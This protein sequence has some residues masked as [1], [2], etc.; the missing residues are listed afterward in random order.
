MSKVF[1]MHSH[2]CAELSTEHIGQEVCLTGWVAKRRDHG[3]LIFV[4]LRDREGI[5]Q[6]TF[7]PDSSGA[8]FAEAERIRPEWSVK[9]EGTVRRRPEGTENTQVKT[10]K[11]EI[12]VHSLQVLNTSK[13]PPFSIEDAI[14]TDE[15]TRMKYRYLDL[16]RP[17]MFKALKLRN[18]MSFA[19][20]SAFAARGFIEVETPI[21]TKSTPEGARDFIVPSRN[22]VGAFYALPQSPQ[23][24]KQLLMVGGIERYY[25]FAR[26]FRDEDLRA[27]RQPE[28]TQVDVEMSYVTQED[29][30][31]TMESIFVECLAQMGVELTVPL[32]R[33]QYRDAMNIYGS[34]RPDTR[35]GMLLHQLCAIFEN[36]EF[37]VFAQAVQTGKVVKCIN[38][39]G[40]A[41]LS[42][43]DIDKLNQFAL[44]HGAQGLAW[45]AF[46]HEGEIKS[47]IK[48]FLSDSEI[49]A[50]KSEME[51]E[52]GDLLL[53]VADELS[54]ANEVLGALRLHLAELLGI[55]RPGHACLWVVNFP[56]FKYDEEEKRYTAEHHPFTMPLLEDLDKIEDRPEEVGTYTYDFVMDGY[57]VGGGTLRIHSAE[58]QLR[59]LKRLGFSEQEAYEQFGFLLDALSYGAPP[60][61]G[62]AL[63]L[64]RLCMLLHGSNTIRDV[65]AFPK[66][67][68]GFDPM[69]Q[70]PDKV[71]VQ[72]LKDLGLR[73]L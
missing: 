31:N 20:R 53:F 7:D 66:T 16:R 47:A 39:K 38:A 54:I 2:S 51:V 73:S 30:L 41:G 62:I 52:D 55:E 27:D 4:D 32:E 42:R 26:C 21:L 9:L 50:L 24:F 48:K 71:S 67:A 43:A 61:A 5:T 25:Q 72:Q 17:E 8:A 14:D 36:S 13:T 3:G 58:L 70:A 28:F 10:G 15:F 63:G 65:I 23:L 22:N 45:I 6:C 59:I 46:T 60:H 49:A 33:M 35:F 57:E 11:I 64:D 18:D 56:M 69:T 40:A 19:L 12:L 29:V 68:S 1:C 34:D 37:K 44:D